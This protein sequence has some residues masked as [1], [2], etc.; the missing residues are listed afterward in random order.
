L[1]HYQ[2]RRGKV[3]EGAS[4]SEKAAQKRKGALSRGMKRYKVKTR[5]GDIEGSIERLKD[6]LAKQKEDG[7]WGCTRVTLS[8]E[9]GPT[10]S[11][12]R[13]GK[14]NSR[15]EGGVA[16]SSLSFLNIVL[17]AGRG[18][19]EKGKER[20]DK[21]RIKASIDGRGG[22]GIVLGGCNRRNEERQKS[23]REIK[24]KTR[25]R[26]ASLRSEKGENA[27]KTREKHGV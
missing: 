14:K 17:Q 13:Q 6:V 2:T 8:S 20:N 19:I 1:L 24:K 18:K 26:R 23:E 3:A 16:G 12:K 27:E 5:E 25:N 10:R 15:R 9:G 7:S 22:F 4:P 21:S 11:R